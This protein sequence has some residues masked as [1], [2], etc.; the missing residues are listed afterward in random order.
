MPSAAN[1]REL[2]ARAEAALWGAAPRP[3][4]VRW[5]LAALRLA[6]A[7]LRDVR[8]GNLSLRATSLVYITFLSLAPL[9]A[10]SFSVL[11]GLGVH[12]ALEPFLLNLVEPLGPQGQDIVARVTG[13][14]DNMR[15]GVLGAVGLVTLVWS[16]VS[17]MGQIEKAF[18]DIWRVPRARPFVLRVRDYLSVLLIGPVFIFVSMA[19]TT[20]LR[21]ADFLEKFLGSGTL[22]GVTEVIGTLAA[23]A[24]FIMAFA[25]LYMFIPYTRVR[26]LPALAA[27]AVTG[28]LWKV[29][30]WLFGVFVAGSASYAAIYSAFAALILFMIWTYVGWL[31]VLAGASVA[32]YMQNPSNQRL[33]RRARH[34]SPRVREKIS[35]L[36]AAEVGTAFYSGLAP[37]GV[38]QLSGALSLPA[39]AVE[40]VAEDLV[41]SGFLA[42]TGRGGFIPGRPFD[43]TTVDD[44]LRAIRSAGEGHGL[45]FA[46]SKTPAAVQAALAA[47]EAALKDALGGITLKQLKAQE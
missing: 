37:P 34:L 42:P 40:D 47:Q 13:F 3:R 22:G 44:M 36:V 14:V 20:A 46:D 31:I 29:L 27:G 5:P 43:A 23:W 24:L 4:Y 1:I 18:N 10:L 7:V 2:A 33:S 39:A 6:A 17:L 15:V 38:A 25:A 35:L 26:P 41:K 9:L 45:G 28:A 11:K 19:L 32:Y 16:V 12:D 21:H 8:E 30:G